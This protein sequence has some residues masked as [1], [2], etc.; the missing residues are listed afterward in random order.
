VAAK[1]EIIELL[2]G[3]TLIASRAGAAILAVPRS[4]LNSRDKADLSPVTA[5]DEAADRL[6]REGLTALMP[7][8]PIVSEENTGNRPAATGQRFLLVDPLD[9]TRDFLAGLDEFTVNIALIENATPVTGVVAAPARGAIWRGSVGHGAERLALAPGAAPHAASERAAIH[10]RPMPS[11]GARV[12]V[13]RF[14]ADPATDAYVGRLPQPERVVCGSSLKFCMIAEGA[15]DLYPR[16]GPISEWDIAAGHAVLAAAGGEVRTPDGGA[17]R[18]GQRDF[19][20]GGFIASGG[21][22]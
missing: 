10:V 1:S 22:R 11:R 12:L 17:L 8:I 16:L 15:A 5:A 2:N 20:V 21:P 4:S 6:I 13:S 18:Y 14:H 19:R 7:G 3:L 9:G